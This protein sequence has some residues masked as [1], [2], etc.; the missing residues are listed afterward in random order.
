M[1]EISH[2]IQHHASKSRNEIALHL[3]GL[4]IRYGEL[5]GLI[6][7]CAH[8]LREELPPP[9]DKHP[10]ALVG[11]STPGLAIHLFALWQMG[12]GVLPQSDRLPE[13]ERRRVAEQAGVTAS[14]CVS[15]GLP[16][17]VG[18]PSAISMRGWLV[19][20]SSGTTGQSKIVRRESDAVD[21][22]ARQVY[23]SVGYRREDI[24]F[25][26]VPLT[27]AYGLEAG[28][29]APLLAGSRMELEDAF[30]AP[31]LGQR[32]TQT[33]ASILTAVPAMVDMLVQMHTGE[34]S[35]PYPDLRWMLCAGA[36]LPEPLYQQCVDRLALRP[37]NYYG[38][39]EMGSV[40]LAD[41]DEPGHDAGRLGR[42]MPGVTMR[43]LNP[44]T[45]EPCAEG[46]V[47]EIAV[48]APSLMTGYLDSDGR[49]D[50]ESAFT[51]IEGKRYFLTGDL[52]TRDENGCFRFVARQKLLIEVGANKVNPMEVEAIL[53][54]HPAVSEA[55]VSGVRLNQTVCRLHADVEINDH[56]EPP[57]PAELRSHCRHHLASW[58]VPRTFE[59]QSLPRTALGKVIR[60]RQQAPA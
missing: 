20:P 41:P 46:V 8:V 11:G 29:L 24:V 58:K 38:A 50:R 19:L 1:R 48:H 7:G 27:H 52:G 59:I 17:A 49:I 18:A 35:D 54:L 12:Y 23:Q 26:A 6:H 9:S 32:L 3:G 39:T 56:A 42:P 44:Q 21:A 10:V 43:I 31:A 30:A 33:R 57:S 14:V 34:G 40:C 51:I 36:P 55:L 15:A 47:G 53:R 2:A 37:A 16:A 25:A 5:P 4:S 60:V 45:R 22:V 13:A 28:L